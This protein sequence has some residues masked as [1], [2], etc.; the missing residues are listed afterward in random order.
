MAAIH[1]LS[2]VLLVLAVCVYGRPARHYEAGEELQLFVNT[3]SPYSNPSETFEY[4]SL[5]FCRPDPLQK[6]KVTLGQAI[7]G[8]RFFTSLYKHQFKG[9]W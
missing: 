6:V 5:P 3:V 9:G 2:L 7:E 1:K 4:Y 8:D